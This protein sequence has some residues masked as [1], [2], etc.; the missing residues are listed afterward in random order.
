MHILLNKALWRVFNSY[1]YCF[2]CYLD[3]D[4]CEMFADD[5]AQFYS[6]FNIIR[7][8]VTEEASCAP[9]IFYIDF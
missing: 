7:A 2:Y 4:N 9:E 3:F 8:I 5:V 6:N 1:Q